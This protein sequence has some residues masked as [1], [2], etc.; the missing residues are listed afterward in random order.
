MSVDAHQAKRVRIAEASEVAAVVDAI[1]SMAP[2]SGAGAWALAGGWLILTGPDFG[3]VNRGM[4]MGLD[5]PI[6]EDDFRFIEER[7]KE[8][9]VPAEVE[10]SPWSDHSVSVV[11]HRRG[12]RSSQSNDLF[13][14]TFDAPAQ[15][16]PAVDI[17][18][19]ESDADFEVWVEVAAAG[20][21]HTE[22]ATKLV[23]W[24]W[25]KGLRALGGDRLLIASMDGHDV[26]VAS[27]AIRD[28]VALLGGMATI[29]E[30]RNRGV[31]RSLISYRLLLAAQS[32][33]EI[34]AAT[35]APGGASE[36]N[37][38]RAGFEIAGQVRHFTRDLSSAG[39]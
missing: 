30:A 11:A 25:G 5:T 31:Q 16:R 12:Y 37:M 26:G 27:L 36:R 1:R 32:G 15:A 13:F 39:S 7:A 17:R 23:M 34:A 4:A 20:F 19:A 38:Q 6:T 24:R 21:G 29:P 22:T 3:Y 9:G 28:G 10:V 8:V 33:C 35:A 18:R 14:R 2:E